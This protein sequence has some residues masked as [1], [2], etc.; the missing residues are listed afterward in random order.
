M[1]TG[2]HNETGIT[3]FSGYEGFIYRINYTDGTVYFGKKNFTVTRKLPPLKGYKRKRTVVKESNWRDYKGSTDWGNFKTIQK[4]SIIRVCKTKG[5]LTYR[6]VETLIQER[7]LFRLDCLNNNISGKFYP[8]NVG[9]RKTIWK[10][11]QQLKN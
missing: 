9:R 1:N 3:D 4:K 7:V 6:E 5:E 10:T 8:T 11:K 2:W